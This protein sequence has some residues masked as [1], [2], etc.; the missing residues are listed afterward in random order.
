[1]KSMMEKEPEVQVVINDEKAPSEELLRA[2]WP[3]LAQMY[4]AK[5][6]R[7]A[8]MLNTT[9][10]KIEGSDEQRLVTFM[11]DNDAQKDWVESKLLHDLEGRLR[12]IV[13]SSGVSLRV[14]VTPA[15][16]VKRVAYMPEEKA[17]ELMAENEEVK[18]L[19]KDLG[20]DVK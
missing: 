11:V 16:A 14:A 5:Q 6:P 13:A 4:A 7:L 8:S 18:N 2:K 20:L 10:L 3:E 19:V 9:T 1:M 15:E 12:R 17:K